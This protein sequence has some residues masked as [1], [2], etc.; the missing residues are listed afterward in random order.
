MIMLLACMCV[1]LSVDVWLEILYRLSSFMSCELNVFFKEW[2]WF[3]LLADLQA[4][5]EDECVESDATSEV[6]CS[7]VK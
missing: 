1:C 3:L 4:A 6:T 2:R 5:G 7:F